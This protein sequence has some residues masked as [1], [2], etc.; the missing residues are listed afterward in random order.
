MGR[1]S[2]MYVN[3]QSEVGR[4]ASRRDLAVCTYVPGVLVRLPE[5]QGHPRTARRA[6][7]PHCVAMSGRTP[8]PVRVRV[9]NPTWSAVVAGQTTS[10]PG[11]VERQGSTKR[12]ALGVTVLC[13]Y[14]VCVLVFH[15]RAATDREVVLL[16]FSRKCG[17]KT[18]E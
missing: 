10:I 4:F 15:T 18:T 7:G 1:T 11:G 17:R 3:K 2:A 8:P 14:F 5:V 13:A 9:G 12:H 16:F 6:E